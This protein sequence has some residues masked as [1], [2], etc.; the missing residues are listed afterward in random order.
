MDLIS[1]RLLS[2]IFF[3]FLFLFIRFW[4]DLKA[5]TIIFTEEKSEKIFYFIKNLQQ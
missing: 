3:Y 2:P 4:C 1:L 5:T